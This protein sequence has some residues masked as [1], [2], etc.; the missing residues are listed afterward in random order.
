MKTVILAG[1][2]G[3]RLAEETDVKPKPTVEIGGRP[4]LWHIM[5]HY[6]H[7]GVGEFLIP[8]G[9][10]GDLI[11]RYFLD[12]AN[13]RSTVSVDLRSGQVERD[14]ESVVEPWSVRLVETGDD[15][16]TGGR[17]LCLRRWLRDETFFLTYGDG[18]SDVDLAQ[19]LA[20]HR[21]HGRQAT[22]T[23]VRPP[24]RFGSLQ[25]DGDQ[26]TAFTE[27]PERGEEWINGGFF[28]LEPGVFELLRGA[29]DSLE[30]D[31]MTQLA[32]L[33]ELRAFR[34]TGFWQ[35]MDTLRDVR[36]LESLWHGEQAPWKVWS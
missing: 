22:V 26:V 20:F 19:L 10:R 12:Y 14:D 4:I 35:C 11:R 8:V 36:L 29:D 30:L 34:H 17:L 18:V 16:Q 24:A 23:A 13:I 3:T 25:L 2:R 33:G 21:A 31:V 5:K 15:T 1:G 32:Q 28:I 7:Y 9:Y 27:K 6:A